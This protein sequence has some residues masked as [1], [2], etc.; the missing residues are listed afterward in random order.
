[1]TDLSLTISVVG[2]VDVDGR[3]IE[4]VVL[5]GSRD[6]LREATTLFG[7]KVRVV[8]VSALTVVQPEPAESVG[9]AR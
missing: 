3:E 9:G 2:S 4:C 6:A 8:P 7:Q 1:M 5:V